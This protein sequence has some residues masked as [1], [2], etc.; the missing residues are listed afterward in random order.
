MPGTRNGYE[1]SHLLSLKLTHAFMLGL[2][3]SPLS[4]HWTLTL[5]S[6]QDLESL[7]SLPLNL[8][9]RGGNLLLV[10]ELPK[11]DVT[12]ASLDLWALCPPDSR[13]LP[14]SSWDPSSSS[15]APGTNHL[16]EA[17]LWRFHYSVPAPLPGCTLTLSLPSASSPQLSC[18]GAAVPPR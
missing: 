1:S 17:G 16:P 11:E 14:L 4:N 15:Q 8:R 13:K 9:L 7:L 12:F 6:I 18:L 3:L 5:L 2:C 10:V